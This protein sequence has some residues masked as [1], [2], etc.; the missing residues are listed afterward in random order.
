[1]SFARL[2]NPIIPLIRSDVRYQ[3]NKDAF[4]RARICDHGSHHSSWLHTVVRREK[5]IRPGIV[6]RFSATE[7][8]VPILDLASQPSARVSPLLISICA[9]QPEYF[10]CLG[11]RESCEDTQFYQLCGLG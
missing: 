4:R 6:I 9:G 10:G 5:P 7:A 2:D 11:Y 8:L 3:F 1:M